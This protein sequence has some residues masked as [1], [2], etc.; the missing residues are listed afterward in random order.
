MHTCC[1]YMLPDLARFFCQ[2]GEM[3]FDFIGR[4][5]KEYVP[6]Q[7]YCKFCRRMGSHSS[8]YHRAT[9]AVSHT[10]RPTGGPERPTPGDLHRERESGSP[11]GGG[12]QEP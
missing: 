8:Q 4:R 6:T 1:V 11:T 9:G 7:Y 2:R 5:V 10:E 3:M 12:P